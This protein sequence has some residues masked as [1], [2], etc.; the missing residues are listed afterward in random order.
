MINYM[1]N[2]T[3]EYL[4]YGKCATDVY[5]IKTRYVQTGDNEHEWLDVTLADI[6]SGDDIRANIKEIAKG[7]SKACEVL[8]EFC[9]EYWGLKYNYPNVKL[10]WFVFESYVDENSVKYSVHK[11]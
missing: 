11:K 4:K 5:Y 6:V 10:I 3:D 2:I 1:N 7:D 9:D 8:Q